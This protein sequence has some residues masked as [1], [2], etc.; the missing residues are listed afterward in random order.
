MNL[1]LREIPKDACEYETI[2]PTA[3]G[4]SKGGH[5]AHFLLA[6]FSFLYFSSTRAKVQDS[7]TKTSISVM[8]CLFPASKL[9]FFKTKVYLQEIDSK[10]VSYFNRVNVR[11]RFFFASLK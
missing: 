10:L 8:E 1:A 6:C 2:G 3:F 5:M 7:R 11:P 9:C 4:I